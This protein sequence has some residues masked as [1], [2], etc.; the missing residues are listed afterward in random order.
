[1]LSRMTNV[2][3]GRHEGAAFT[4]FI[5][6]DALRTRRKVLNFEGR[7]C[8]LSHHPP[9]KKDRTMRDVLIFFLIVLTANHAALAGGHRRHARLVGLLRR[10]IPC[11]R[12]R[13]VAATT[14]ECLAT[15]ACYEFGRDLS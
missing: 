3:A 2:K 1:M 7:R 15:M 14:H 9:K 10:L 11:V 6:D 4:H 5:I 13:E 12:A 8:L